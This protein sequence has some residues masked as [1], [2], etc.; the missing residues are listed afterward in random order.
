MMRLSSQQFYCCCAVEVESKLMLLIALSQNKKLSTGVFTDVLPSEIELVY[1][2]AA[3]S[4]TPKLGG[5]VCELKYCPYK[6]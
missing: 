6:L 3:S 5:E 1:E 2:L 4:Y